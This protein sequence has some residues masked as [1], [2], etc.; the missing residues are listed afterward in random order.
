MIPY[1]HTRV[2]RNIMRSSTSRWK[3]CGLLRPTEPCSDKVGLRTEIG[4][5]S[6]PSPQ[7][8]LYLALH[9]LHIHFSS[10][11][12]SEGPS[13]SRAVLSL[14]PSGRSCRICHPIQRYSGKDVSPGPPRA[15]GS[16]AGASYILNNSPEGSS[17]SST[18]IA[19][20]ETLGGSKSGSTNGS[21][22]IGANVAGVANAVNNLCSSGAIMVSDNAS[23]LRT[24][25][26]SCLN[27]LTARE[28]ALHSQSGSNT[29]VVFRI[30]KQDPSNLQ[31]IGSP[32]N[33]GGHSDSASLCP[34]WRQQCRRCMLHFRRASLLGSTGPSP[35][36]DARAQPDQSSQRDPSTA[37]RILFNPTLTPQH[38]SP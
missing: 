2:S 11:L 20:N 12:F 23:P 15:H 28:A 35:A 32:A 6:K 37:F 5:L 7:T 17:V 19:E 22:A 21:G 36:L 34:Q 25:D 26:R 30:D 9:L 16:R 10:R 8:S 27:S 31:M 4:R 18:Q 33:T 24:L 38:S 14:F 29:A 3:T 1:R 13:L